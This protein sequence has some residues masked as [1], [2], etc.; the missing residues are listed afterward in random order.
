[1]KAQLQYTKDLS[2]FVPHEH[3]QPMSDSHSKHIAESMKAGGFWPSKPISCVKKGGRLVVV[4]GHH[5]L[6]AAKIA[7]VGVYYVE[8]PTSRLDDIGEANVLVRKWSNESFAKMYAGQGNPHYVELLRYVDIGVPLS[9][10]ASVLRGEAGHSGNAGKFIRT[11]DFRIKTRDNMRVIASF[12]EELGGTCDVVTTKI[13]IEALSVLLFVPEFDASVL[14]ARIR[15]NPLTLA[16][17]NNREQML[18]Q[19]EEV[20]NFRSR[21]KVP[22]AFLAKEKMKERIAVGLKK[23]AA[24]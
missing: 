2:A 7:A 10:A 16:K 8:E 13:F 18:Q 1:M 14:K 23:E 24:A 9:V 17:C 11:G 21:E 20:Y 5:R 6:A 4:D 19:I 15:S 3:Q 22:L 12:I